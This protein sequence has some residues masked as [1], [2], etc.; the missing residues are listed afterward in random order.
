MGLGRA[1]SCTLSSFSAEKDLERSHVE[2]R[3]RTAWWAGGAVFL[4]GMTPSSSLAVVCHVSR[5][6]RM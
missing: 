2:F 5:V 6:S 4:G 1:C 3:L